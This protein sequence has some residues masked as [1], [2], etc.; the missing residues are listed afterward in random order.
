MVLSRPAKGELADGFQDY[1]STKN[2]AGA[3]GTRQRG[4]TNFGR[5]RGRRRSGRDER[6]GAARAYRRP[7]AR[8]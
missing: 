3:A 5:L 4:Q 1:R 2:V 7:R 8:A 6:Y